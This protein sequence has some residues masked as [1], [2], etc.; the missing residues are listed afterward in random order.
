DKQAAVVVVAFSS[1][2]E[3]EIVNIVRSCDRMRREIF[4]V[5]RLFEVHSVSR[6]VDSVWGIPLIRLRRPALSRG[7]S[8]A[9]RAFDA[10][11]AA[12]AMLVLAPVMA[13]I[14]VG[15]RLD[16]SPSVLYAQD[17]IG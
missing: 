13:A 10:T 3:S 12:L 2:S 17:R 6:G 14:A 16:G 5:P 7:R 8:G 11:A 9:K 15:L 4:L 1:D